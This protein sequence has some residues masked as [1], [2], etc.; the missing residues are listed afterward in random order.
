MPFFMGYIFIKVTLYKLAKSS[1]VEQGYLKHF[2]MRVSFKL[3]LTYLYSIEG[4]FKVIG[5]PR[6]IDLSNQISETCK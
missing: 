2:Y 5:W 3:K 6:W 4:G 1:K